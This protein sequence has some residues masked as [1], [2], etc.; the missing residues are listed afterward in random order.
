MVQVKGM[1]R[2]S[3]NINKATSLKDALITVSNDYT[4]ATK[5]LEQ[6]KIVRE[7]KEKNEKQSLDVNEIKKAPKI[8]IDER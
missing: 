5:A 3:R 7:L 4:E 8:I 1:E 6:K 2:I